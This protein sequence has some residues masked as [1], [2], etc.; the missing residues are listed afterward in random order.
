[1]ENNSLIWFIAGIFFLLTEILL[2]GFIIFFFGIGGLVTSLFTY[3]FNIDSIIVQIL[4]FISSSVLSLVFLRN[5]FSK[6]FRGKVSGDKVLEDE[7]VG[8]RAVVIHEI[9]PDSLSGKVEFNGTNW[10]AKSDSFIDKGTVVEIIERK[11]LKLIVKPL[12]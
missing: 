2:P 7:F 10:E 11:D 9:I 4:I 1:M 12:E 8:K 5:T 6:L 3:I